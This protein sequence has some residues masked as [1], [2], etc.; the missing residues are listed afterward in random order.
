[1]PGGLRLVITPHR[2]SL[3]GATGEELAA[4]SVS[5]SV[6]RRVDDLLWRLGRARLGGSSAEVDYRLRLVGEAL[7]EIF[8]AGPVGEALATSIAEERTI[9]IGVRADDPSLRDLPWEACILPGLTRPL[10][11]E[12]GFN[13]YREVSRGGAALPELRAP[14]RIVAV[15]AAL[16]D[17]PPLNLD[18]EVEHI[19]Q[20]LSFP[21]RL[22]DS[23]VRLVS[24][25]TLA[26]VRDAIA[27][28]PFHVAHLSCHALPGSVVLE[29]EEGVG[30]LVSA[31]DLAIALRGIALLVLAGCSTA[32]GG[33]NLPA[34]A[35]DL[36]AAGIPAVVAMGGPVSD[37]FSLRLAGHFYRNLTTSDEP[38][39]LTALSAARREL[40][41]AR[42]ASTADGG[43]TELV[44][45]ATPVL[46]QG[47]PPRPLFRLA[48]GI[49]SNVPDVPSTNKSLVGRRAELHSLS[50]YLN[51]RSL[52]VLHGI[53]G[54]GKTQLAKH[55]VSLLRTAGQRTITVEGEINAADL[56]S[57]D[58]PAILLCDR[59]EV[60]LMREG[61]RGYSVRN[62]EIADLL[63]EWSQEPDP[64]TIIFTSRYPFQLGHGHT[65]LVT[66]FQPTLLGKASVALL[67]FRLPTL[68][69]LPDGDRADAMEAIGGHPY[70]LEV[71]EAELASG[72]GLRE[73]VDSCIQ[74]MAAHC[75]LDHGLAQLDAITRTVLLH[76]A[77]YRIS[78]TESALFTRPA[79]AWVAPEACEEALSA[80]IAEGL[81]IQQPSTPDGTPMLLVP[82]W[83]ATALENRADPDDVRQAHRFAAFTY[84][85]ELN[86]LHENH[87]ERDD[88][89]RDEVD[90]LTETRYHHWRAGEQGYSN[91]ATNRLSKLLAQR[92]QRYRL[93]VMHRE[94]LRWAEVDSDDAGAAHQ[95]LAALAVDRGDFEQARTH[96]MAALRIYEALGKRVNMAQ[97]QH[98]LAVIDEQLGRYTEA[99]VHC[100]AAL[101]LVGD[102][103]AP[104]VVAACYALLGNLA[105]RRDDPAY[106]EHYDRAISK[107][108]GTAQ[109]E[110]RLQ[111]AMIH[112]NRAV[113][114]ARQGDHE[115]AVAALSEAAAIY[116]E[117]GRDLEFTHIYHTL[118]LIAQAQGD[119][120]TAQAYLREAVR[121]HESVGNRAGAALNYHELGILATERGDLDAAESYHRKG[122]L[123][124]QEADDLTAVA[125]SC[126]ELGLI[127]LKK[128]DIAKARSW[129]EQALKLKN[130]TGDRPHLASSYILLGRILRDQGETEQAC[131]H[132]R[133]AA[134]LG[135]EFSMLDNI[136]IAYRDLGDIALEQGRLDDAA[137]AF[138]KAV[139]AGRLRHR[140]DLLLNDIMQLAFIR[141]RQE[142]LRASSAL[143]REAL[144]L[145]KKENDP[146]KMASSYNQL[147]VIALQEGEYGSARE[148]L[149]AALHIAEELEDQYNTAGTLRNL[150]NVARLAGDSEQA[151]DY[152]QRARDI[153][154][155]IDADE[156]AAFGHEEVADVYYA[157]GNF[158]Q[159]RIELQRYA[160]AARTMGDVDNYMDALIALA[161]V[162]NEHGDPEQAVQQAFMAY[163]QGIRHQSRY[164]REAL[165]L[166]SQQSDTLGAAR[167]R[168]ILTDEFGSKAA[169]VLDRGLT[170]LNQSER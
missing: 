150:G 97:A 27:E 119:N 80:F 70:A 134:D 74:T 116:R 118:A 72:S 127:S 26:A 89:G 29:D 169:E 42:L 78:V 62:K 142:D 112:G 60:N 48:D 149:T 19:H 66:L 105:A 34:L 145:A 137:S 160:E 152:Y 2:T 124:G 132:L 98:G 170:A 22:A 146:Y 52:L 37:D 8:C 25:G 12:T 165:E 23:R 86:A 84:H 122:L 99:A 55:L 11:L 77:A 41:A 76:A 49:D 108:T 103:D 1:M 129:V 115:Q 111:I 136:T 10:A 123:I 45:W 56:R 65:E 43:R 39:P 40:E 96:N 128:G 57:L 71:L 33:E 141:L 58:R 53:E 44:E 155:T 120:S 18:A 17:G 4:T 30:V 32:V 135:T 117:L 144:D 158:D 79:D 121:L 95:S 16:D 163:L 140:P 59:F 38:D 113:A 67:A 7:G 110:Q 104:R 139:T 156:E 54:I 87:V 167:I 61:L 83:L 50:V 164:A 138:D 21:L 101:E 114:L 109:A 88:A 28:G 35:R 162:E 20:A 147:G 85:M 69:A 5:E 130:Q 133:A 166:L 3:L 153:F 148:H 94:S 24:P 143:Y 13:I 36:V 161:K 102:L 154:V 6:E 90:L 125:Y 47:G 81:V 9:P 157:L 82:R 106:Q 14:L 91:E 126:H 64:V 107:L 168:Q 15:L 151:I 92:G 68:N 63:G 31:A 73:A 159:A 46:F 93:E 75:K 131:V 100:A 51:G